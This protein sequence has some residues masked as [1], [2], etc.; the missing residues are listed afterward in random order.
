MKILVTITLMLLACVLC[1]ISA[2]K[3]INSQI[4]KGYV[5]LWFYPKMEIKVISIAKTMQIQVKDK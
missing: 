4:K 2:Q 5:N 3:D 1:N